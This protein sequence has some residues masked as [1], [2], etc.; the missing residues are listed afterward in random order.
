[1]SESIFD[2]FGVDAAEVETD[3]FAIPRNK[4]IVTVTEAGVKEIKDIPYFIVELTITDKT[5]EH[6]GKNANMM[7]RISKWTDA[8]RPE[9]DAKTMNA[10][11]IGQYKKCLLDLGIKPEM[12][13]QFN[14]RTMGNGLLGIKGTATI[15]PN[16]NGYNSIFD[17]TREVQASTVAE[18]AQATAQVSAPEVNAEAL[19]ALMNGF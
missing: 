12:L 18:T 8:E 13:N 9:G 1:M 3:P 11:T 5:S 7:N 15:G 10:R 14:P 16:K 4:Y 19:A 2:L 6:D 17:F